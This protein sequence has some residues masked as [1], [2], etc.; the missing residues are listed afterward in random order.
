MSQSLVRNLIHLI[1]STRNRRPLITSELR[2]EL[3][4]YMVGIIRNTDS[5]PIKIGAVEDHVH[6]FVGLSKKTA[7]MDLL[8]NI[9]RS[10]SEWCRKKGP[11]FQH[12]AWQG[13][14]AGFSVS[15]SNKE[16]VIK[17]IEQQWEYHQRVSYRE[18]IR[19]FIERHEM[20]V[21]EEYMFDQ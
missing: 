5:I 10:S 14:Y 15:E 1:W 18:E 6:C 16:D 4:K 17:Y 13:G 20:D 21:N 8:R 19:E 2:S 3:E 12:F 7:L 11:D 9:K